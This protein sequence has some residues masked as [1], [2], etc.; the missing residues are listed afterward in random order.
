VPSSILT[1]L[2]AV[3][4]TYVLQMGTAAV[5]FHRVKNQPPPSA[6]DGWPSV[7]VIVPARNEA[8][9]IE[10]CLESLRA[11]NY[12]ADRLEIIVVD[13]FSTDGTSKRVRAHQPAETEKTEVIS[14][15]LVELSEHQSQNG[16]HKPAAV[17][18]GVDAAMGDVILTTDA[19]CAVS[20]T[21][22]KSM[23]RRCTPDTP[24]VAGPVTYDHDELFL[25]RLQALE[26]VGLV[27]YGAGTLTM[28][29][30]TFCNSANVAYRRDVLGDAQ[31]PQN[32]AASDELLLQ[33]VAYDTDLTVTFNP[34]PGAAVT[35]TPTRSFVQYLQQQARWAHM[36]LRYP[37]LVP[38]VLVVGLWTTHALLFLA[39]A[40]ALAIPAWREPMLLL[41]LAK[42]GGDAIVAVPSARHFGQGGLLRSAVPTELLL[43]FSVPLIGVLGTLGGLEWKGRELE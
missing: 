19:D 5:G 22:V 21:W 20:P 42:M 35:T 41:F 10:G 1:L 38:K 36:G 2:I 18:H 37:Y 29:L 11:V 31:P 26:L 16:N 27:A 17:A 24:F 9:E 34:D 12:P 4:A 23:V 40:V 25:P 39:A 32:G 28:G 7:S 8:D 6:P 30:P 33:H 14:V 3:V 43:L 13:D 15:R